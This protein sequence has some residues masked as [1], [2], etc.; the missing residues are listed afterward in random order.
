MKKKKNPMDKEDVVHVYNG[1]LLSVKENEI[2]P[3]IATWED[4]E[5]LILSEES[6]RRRNTVWQTSLI[7]EPK[8]KWYKL[9]YLQNRKRLKDREG[10]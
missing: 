4:L 7:R 2:L 5:T 8:K 1:V 10:T 3:L 9:T 6:Q